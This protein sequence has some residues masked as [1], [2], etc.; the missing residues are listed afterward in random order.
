MQHG[1]LGFE[2]RVH[3]LGDLLKSIF[4]LSIGSCS[5]GVRGPCNWSL[6]VKFPNALNVLSVRHHP[7]T[8]GS[9]SRGHNSLVSYLILMIQESNES[10]K[11]LVSN[12]KIFTGFGL[13]IR[14]K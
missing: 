10:L 14:Q 5:L 9:D 13:A 7:T 8:A 12:A 6:G 2:T 4:H 3:Q 1:K 11:S